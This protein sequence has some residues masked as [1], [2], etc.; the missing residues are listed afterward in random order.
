M[1]YL[2][3]FM[4]LI[5][6]CI[7]SI[8]LIFVPDINFS[9]T[10]PLMQANLKFNINQY[11]LIML[12]LG[13]FSG[14]FFAMFYITQRNCLLKS[15]QSKFERMSIEKD[16]DKSKVRVLENKIKTLEQ[17]LKRSMKDNKDH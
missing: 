7:A 10:I 13:L 14:I 17:A 1:K 11:S 2:Y 4:L 16:S 15:Y 8:L 6:L 3:L 9:I 12:I 5:S